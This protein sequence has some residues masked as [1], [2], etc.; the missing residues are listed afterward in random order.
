MATLTRDFIQQRRRSVR[1]A[2]SVITDMTTL[3]VSTVPRNASDLNISIN[4][5]YS[6]SPA[7]SPDELVIQKR[8]RRRRTIVWSP[9]VD[10]K[11]DSLLSNNLND[12]TPVKSTSRLSM[13][14]HN[15]PRKRLVLDD[16]DKNDYLTPEQQI[17]KIN[18]I[19]EQKQ[20]NGNLINGLRGLS[21]DQLVKVIMDLVSMQEDGAIKPDEQLRDV[22][23]KRMPV[24]DIQPLKET[25]NSL[26][27]N[28][29]GSLVSSD[30][31]SEEDA[32]ERA[33]V[34]LD[35]YEKTLH[36]QGEK[37]ITSQH[38]TS[39]MQ[40][41]FAAWSITKELPVWPHQHNTVHKCYGYLTTFAKNAL[42]NGSFTDSALEVFSTKMETMSHDC[43]DMR[44]C[45]QIAKDMIRTC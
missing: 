6:W 35:A 33:S 12:R 36:E 37:L 42:L 25:L 17:K 34:Y 5:R 31:K 11:R 1:Q 2:L 10:K 24:A 19:N 29:F 20:Y 40:Y 13:H 9:E 45:L 23:M 14:N 28:V 39:V 22:I 21:N 8:G 44:I 18:S 32:F 38:W 41:V 16:N 15:T 7:P 30:D 27:Q 3:S 4:G 26:R 43:E